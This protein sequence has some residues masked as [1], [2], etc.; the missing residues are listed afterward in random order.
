M[1]YHPTP[2]LTRDVQPDGWT[3]VR[4]PGESAG[5]ALDPLIAAL[6]AAADGR[7]VAEVAQAARV[8]TYLA[9]AA[10]KVLQRAGVLS[11]EPGSTAEA[12]GFAERAGVAAKGT[13]ASW[14][15][16]PRA[17]ASGETSVSALVLHHDP[18]ANLDACLTSLHHQTY[19]LA[20]LQTCPLAHLQTCPLAH[21]QTC[22]LAHLQTCPLADLQTCKL[23][24]LHTCPSALLLLDSHT[25]LSPSALAEMVAVLE[26]RRDIAAVVPRVMWASWPGFVVRV[27]DWRSPR[28]PRR[29]PFAGWLDVGQF[30]ADWLEVPAVHVSAALLRREALEALPLDLRYG[31]DWLGN[32]WS[33]RAQAAGWYTAAA[34][35][36]LAFAPWPACEDNPASRRDERRFVADHRSERLRDPLPPLAGP[37]LHEG[38]PA[39]TLEALRSTYS[40]APAVAPLP[41]RR[42]V[43]FVGQETARHR[44]MAGQLATT[45]EVHWLVPT[46]DQDEDILRQLCESADLLIATAAPLQRFDFLQQWHRPILVDLQPPPTL[47]ARLGEAGEAPLYQQMDMFVQSPQL[48]P[49]TVDGVICASEEERLY[50]LG[51][52]AAS[53]RVNPYT[54]RDDPALCRLVLVVP[55]GV[56][57]LPPPQPVLKGVRPGIE[58]DDPL[59]LWPGGLRPGDDPLTV[60]RGFAQARQAH[61][62]A[63]LVFAAFDD[64][65]QDDERWTAAVDLA[66]GLGLARVVLFERDVPARL[67]SGYLAEA[68]LAVALSSD[69]VG[70]L[71]H[72]PVGLAAC[73]GAG[74]PMLVTAGCAGSGRVERYGL[75]RAVAPGDA[76][77][78]AQALDE[79]LQVPRATYRHRFEAAAAALA[80]PQVIAPLTRFCAQPRYAADRQVTVFLFRAGQLSAPLPTP[81]WALPAR[82]WRFLTQKGW[83]ATAREIVQ[84]VRWKLEVRG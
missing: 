69:G 51:Q 42:R 34:L 12:A 64:E 48:W 65:P 21:L 31:F 45:C 29:N 32:D 18:H 77:A 74:L 73:I 5:I 3:L 35:R 46:E 43:V 66:T 14:S 79:C 63:R 70:A 23:A 67:R 17:S 54:V 36:A 33:R 38:M 2:A 47:A 82:A 75:G 60:L 72:E 7:A 6:A 44:A 76:S 22:P 83:R 16:Q 56:E 9:A 40:F 81:F 15:D 84:Y 68:E 37:Q 59:I 25:L 62:R 10:L 13:S 53:G 78:L 1:T 24:H 39:L 52:L 41:A 26:L 71:L 80:W 8:S 20:H 28:Q 30:E 4:R 19:P 27:G 58:M 50:W 49:Q 61:P 11:E 55:T 57:P